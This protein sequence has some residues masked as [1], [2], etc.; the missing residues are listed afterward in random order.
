MCS[1]EVSTHTTNAHL[2]DEDIP[3]SDTCWIQVH[4]TTENTV[5]PSVQDAFEAAG[6]LA[7]TLSETNDTDALW[8]PEPGTNPLWQT[9]CVTGLF[10]A[11]SMRHADTRDQLTRQLT[12]LPLI[13]LRWE[14]LEDRAWEREWMKH[15]KPMLIANRLLIQP[16][17]DDTDTITD[18]INAPATPASQTN[19]PSTHPAPTILR[20]DP[21]L[22]FGTGSHPTTQLCLT[23]LCQQDLSGAS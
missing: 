11:N 17:L 6:A 10:H 23:W 21:G 8:E 12:S 7:I 1:E 4:A 14:V 15:F 2:T 18:T 22:A 20:L 3:S 19:S 5:V 16:T 9:T 13:N